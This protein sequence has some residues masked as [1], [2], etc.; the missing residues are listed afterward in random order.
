MKPVASI[1]SKTRKNGNDASSLLLQENAMQ[2]TIRFPLKF[3]S[4]KYAYLSRGISTVLSALLLACA[5]IIPSLASAQEAQT[6]VIWK[7]GDMSVTAIQDLSGEMAISFFSGPASEQARSKYFTNGKAAAGVNAFLLRTGGKIVLFD[8]G[9]GTAFQSQG[10]LF[11][12]LARLGVQPEE[13]DVVLLTH[14]HWDHIGGLLREGQRAFPKAKLM[15]SKPELESWLE[16][17]ARDI[18]NAP[19]GEIKDKVDIYGIDVQPFAF[20]DSPLPGV[21]ALD[22]SGHT[23]GHTVFQLTAGGKSLLIVGDIVHAMSLQLALPDECATFDMDPPQAIAA[24]KR[25]LGLAA[26]K[27]IPIA[28]MHVPFANTVGTVKKDGK[29]WKFQRM[30]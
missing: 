25:I 28:G 30:K 22:A 3:L 19:A 16:L 15:V 20:G 26:Q 10:R 21:T 12:A 13:V 8:T 23:P 29:G 1:F 14:M 4:E 18:S 2:P 17:A 11:D 24:R 5:L 27:A 6:R 7:A 9:V